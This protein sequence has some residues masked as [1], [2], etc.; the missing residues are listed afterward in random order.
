MVV[1]CAIL[2]TLRV[3]FR[4]NIVLFC[5]N[6]VVGNDHKEL[7]YGGDLGEMKRQRYVRIYP[8]H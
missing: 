6:M 8:M 5:A 3:V 7:G 1:L 2:T 4:A